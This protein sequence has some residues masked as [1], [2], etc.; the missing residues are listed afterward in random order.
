MPGGGW[1]LCFVV[2]VLTGEPLLQHNMLTCF[3]C[4]EVTPGAEIAVVSNIAV[5]QAQNRYDSRGKYVKTAIGGVASTPPE[6]SFFLLAYLA[7]RGR[8]RARTENEGDCDG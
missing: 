8:A 6:R 1:H 2:A 5:Q 7:Y 3:C 4:R